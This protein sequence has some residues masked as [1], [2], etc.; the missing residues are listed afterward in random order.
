MVVD[1]WKGNTTTAVAEE[2][3]SG[4]I[5]QLYHNTQGEADNSHTPYTGR[6]QKQDSSTTGNWNNVQLGNRNRIALFRRNQTNRNARGNLP[7]FLQQNPLFF[8]W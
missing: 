4:C 7:L 8:P 2:D 1:Y 3:N 5:S 6:D